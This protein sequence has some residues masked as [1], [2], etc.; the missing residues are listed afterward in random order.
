M[1]G[2]A[3]H[4]PPTEALAS[5]GVSISSPQPLGSQSTTAGPWTPGPST[6]PQAPPISEASH[7]V[8][9]MGAGSEPPQ[10]DLKA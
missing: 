2:A 3:A 4:G 1:K 10:H 9:L 7:W 5:S 8:G 6:R